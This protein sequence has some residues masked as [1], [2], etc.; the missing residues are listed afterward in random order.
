MFNRKKF[1]LFV[2]SAIVTS[3]I[4]F[5]P[6]EAKNLEIKNN[7]TEKI[8]NKTNLNSSKKLTIMVYMDADNNLEE[9]LLNDLEEMKKGYVDNPNLNLIVLIDRA[10]NESNNSSVLGENFTDTRMY[11]IEH[12]KAIRINGGHEF[13]EITTKSNYEANM[14]DAKTLKKFI[15][16][17]KANYTADKYMLVMSNHGGGTRNKKLNKKLNKAICWDDSTYDEIAD[18]SD[19]LYIGEI[20]DVLTKKES[21][22]VLAFDACLMGTAEVAYQLR[23]NN[24]GFEAKYMVASAPVEWSKGYP[25][26]KI[27]NRLR[28]VDTASDEEDL[29]LGGKEKYFNPSNISD[30]ELG[31]LIIEEQRDSVSKE[32]ASDQEL[33]FYDLTKVQ[34]LKISLDNLARNLSIENKKEEIE[35]I[36]GNN[37]KVSLIHYFN[38]NDKYD[39]L[40]YSYFDLY[41]LCEKISCNSRL[42]ENTKRLAKD[43][44]RNIDDMVLYS[45][46]GDKFKGFK[47]GKNGLSIFF[48]DGNREISD[49]FTGQSFTS[50]Q[51]QRWY[52]SIDTTKELYLPY[53]KLSWCKDGQDPE[54]NKVGNWFELLDSWFDKT[55]DK[56]GGCNHYQW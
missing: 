55:N 12:N 30:K 2:A 24:G 45:F 10:K 49:S 44:M 26:D 37:N 17:C 27:L 34:A 21:V 29:T 23:P 9:D 48:P 25:Y 54:I 4:G 13:S 46:G 16:S 41:D 14:G 32:N 20:S 56:S 7:K 52:N 47:E 3:L 31:A 33:S 15:K 51:A 6:V 50:W 36:R 35:N 38:E 28:E 40:D 1:N 43:T 11:K 18:D 42:S 53:G 39:W 8:H 19:C 5:I 22:D